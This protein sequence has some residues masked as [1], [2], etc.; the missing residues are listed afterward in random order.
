MAS[1]N[2]RAKKESPEKS[3]LREYERQVEQS[4]FGFLRATSALRHTRRWAVQLWY[5][6]NRLIHYTNLAALEGMVRSQ[7]VWLSDHRFLNDQREYE[8]GRQL[9]ITSLRKLR[10]PRRGKFSDVLEYAAVSLEKRA[11]PRFFVCSFTQ[12]SDSL[13]QWRAYANGP[14]GVAISFTS[15]SVG[16][17]HH[18]FRALPVML[19]EAVLYEHRL[20]ARRILW[21]IGA[22][23]YEYQADRATGYAKYEDDWGE[24]L[25]TSL[26]QDFLLFKDAAFSAEREVRL[27]VSENHLNHFPSGI[28]HRVSGARL[29]P[30]LKSSDLYEGVAGAEDGARLPIVEVK[31]GPTAFDSLTAKSVEIFLRDR[32]YSDVPVTRSGLPYRG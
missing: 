6:E 31:L 32:G 28:H 2:N 13:E 9:A 16:G 18:H 7:A 17:R 24:Q 5:R 12:A 11:E 10:T 1:M 23:A 14:Q 26:A 21:K 15:K 20:K 30:Y 8:D 27:I 19:A 4:P 25:A 22:F 29:I 3:L